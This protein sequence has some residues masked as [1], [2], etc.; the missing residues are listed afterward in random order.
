MTRKLFIFSFLLIFGIGISQNTVGVISNTSNAYNGYTLFTSNKK[1]FLIN[2]CGEVIHEWVSTFNPGNSVY[3]LANGNL[4]RAGRTESV[5]ITFGGQGGVIELYSW[6]GVL[7]WQYYYDTPEY[8]QHHDIFPMQNGNIL[9]L[10][11]KVMSNSEAIQA[12]RNPLLLPQSELF[13]EQIVEVQPIGTNQAN[14]VWEW[15]IRDHL[16]QDFDDTKD[17]FGIVSENPNKL[18]INFTNGSIGSSNWLHINS[19]QYNE[20]LDQI[21]LSSRN[22]S[23]IWIIDHSTSTA[24]AAT[25]EGGIYGQGGDLIYRW[26]NPKAYKMGSDIDQKLF[27]QHY[28]HWIADGLIDGGKIILFNNGNGRI[29]QFSEVNILNPPTLSPGTYFLEANGTFGPEIPD[30]IYSDTSTI[31]SPFLS[32]IL[33]SAERLPNGNI[34]ICE[35][36]TG[37]IFEID[38]QQ[39]IVWKYINP[40]HNVSGI[41]A[42]QGQSPP[43]FRSLFRATRFSEDYAAFEGRDLTPGNPIELNSEINVPCSTLNLKTHSQIALILSPNPTSGWINITSDSEIDKIEIYT[44]LGTKISTAIHSKTINVSSFQ[45]GIYLLRIFIEDR[46]LTKKIIKR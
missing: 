11:A 33:S 23:E 31:P 40:V 19:V 27:G 45:S 17:N 25:S 24:Q 21:I 37:E 41:I 5:D 1:S 4:L 34:L 44:I 13:S 9:I 8:R 26:G 46:I 3:L 10:A 14:I 16:I 18:D 20:T 28:P 38:E 30:Y 35:G 6:E 22:L 43:D 32:N 2:N 15:D 7:I 39:N 36:S 12:G 29:P 42:E